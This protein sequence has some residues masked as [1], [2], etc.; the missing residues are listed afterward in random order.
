M[1]LLNNGTEE[2]KKR[3]NPK[4][5][6]LISQL[7]VNFIGN[8]EGRDVLYGMA[9]VLVADGFT[10]NVFLKAIEGTA[11]YFSKNLKD[12]LMKNILT[13]ISALILKG[14]ISEFKKKF[15]YNEHGG[16]PVLGAKG[17]VIKAHGSSNALAFY[18]AIRQAKKSTKQMLLIP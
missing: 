10:G 6:R 11:L 5:Y 17:A 8:V 13:K 9:D 14:G 18:N 15:D 4:R 7:P 16:A 2:H 1:G 3:G 12:M